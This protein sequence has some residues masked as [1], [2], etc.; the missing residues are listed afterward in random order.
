MNKISSKT[1]RGLCL[2]L[3]PS[4]ALIMVSLI[5][6]LSSAFVNFSYAQSYTQSRSTSSK[7]TDRSVSSSTYSGSAQEQCGQDRRCRLER[8]K[9]LNQQR[10]Q[11][12]AQGQKQR[13]LK[14]QE[15]INKKTL[16]ITPRELRPFLLDLDVLSNPSFTGS[17]I[18]ISWQWLKHLR[19]SGSAMFTCNLNSTYNDNTDYYFDGRC[20]KGG[21]RYLFGTKNLSSYIDVYG[22]HIV[23]DGELSFYNTYNDNYDGGFFEFASEPQLT[24][25]YVSGELESHLIGV[26][27]GFDWQSKKGLH[28]RFGLST[29]YL[30]FASIRNKETR[31]NLTD[32]EI[33][34]LIV[35][36]ALS[37]TFDFSIGYAF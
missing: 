37:L 2:S 9:L 3:S 35:N 26:G 24:D 13:T 10:K 18:T 32:M 5:V 6:S 4:Y 36:D 34:S 25:H 21:V 30:L 19:L 28:L 27:V 14:F 31:A 1:D 11:S 16:R 23:V 12:R 8:L 33:E 22:M 29:H 17:G 15:D 7:A 20:F